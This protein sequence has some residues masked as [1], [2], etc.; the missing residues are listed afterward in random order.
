MGETEELFSKMPQ[1]S[2]VSWNAIASVWKQAGDM[3]LVE[4]TIMDRLTRTVS[5]GVVH[6]REFVR[7]DALPEI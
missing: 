3:A 1:K 7:R 2:P 5:L 6:H 4:Y